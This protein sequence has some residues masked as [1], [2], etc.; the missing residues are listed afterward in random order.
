MK[1]SP[2]PFCGT[3][4]LLKKGL[5]ICGIV[6]LYQITCASLGCSVTTPPSINLELLQ[7]RW[8]RRYENESS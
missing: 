7:A 3:A 6:R 1:L 8:N 4:P 2:C 5:E